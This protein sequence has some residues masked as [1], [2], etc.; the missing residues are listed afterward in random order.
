MTTPKQL[1]TMS[2]EMTPIILMPH[3]VKTKSAFCITCVH[4]FAIP[5]LLHA[6]SCLILC[7]Q[8]VTCV[9]EQS[10]VIKF[11][12]KNWRLLVYRRIEMDKTSKHLNSEKQPYKPSRWRQV[13]GK[14]A[15]LAAWPPWGATF[16]KGEFKTLAQPP[17]AC[18][19]LILIHRAKLHYAVSLLN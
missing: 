13:S 12:W 19:E 11:Q 3:L 16:W 9:F 8:S 4:E 7:K 14:M 5:T 18:C 2:L 10:N 15:L 17:L 1:T 6:A